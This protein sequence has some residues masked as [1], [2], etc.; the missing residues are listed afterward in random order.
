MALR[1]VIVLATAL[2]V[3]CTGS[4]EDAPYRVTVDLGPA[5]RDVGVDDLARSEAARAQLTGLGGAALPALREALAREPVATRAALVEVLDAL[6]TAD[7][8][9]MLI[10]LAGQDPSEDVRYA[11]VATLGTSKNPEA[12]AVL[13]RALADESPRIR[14]AA[15]GTC[16]QNCSAA[17]AVTA[18]ATMGVRD[19][20][21]PNGMAARKALLRLCAAEDPACTTAVREI[22]LATLRAVLAS[23]QD[24]PAA[25]QA[26]L[27]AADQN[28]PSGAAVLV[29]AAGRADLAPIARLGAVHALGTVG[30]A[31]AVPV[32]VELDGDTPVAA[33]AYDALRR[34][35]QRGVREAG[36][37]LQR[38]KGPRPAAPLPAPLF[39]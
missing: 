6:P 36:D 3:G 38:W 1:C 9:P 34:L 26:A 35:S 33:Y 27:L 7:G 18:L 32:L 39:G 20:L 2:A 15:A 30:D 11:A 19:P 10:A 29:R 37:S 24:S 12:A 13:A 21:V 8:E 4:G 5:I 17:D 25:F 23:D 31:G 16:A 22:V 28:D 14:L